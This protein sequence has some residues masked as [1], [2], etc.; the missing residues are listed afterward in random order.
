MDRE[1]LS[2]ASGDENDEEVVEDTS[3]TEKAERTLVTMAMAKRWVQQLTKVCLD[4]CLISFC[5]LSLS[6]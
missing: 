2:A 4:L 5:P 1:G 3:H 6:L